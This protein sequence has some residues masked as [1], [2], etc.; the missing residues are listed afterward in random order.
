MCLVPRILILHKCSSG[1]PLGGKHVLVNH[2]LSLDDLKLHGQNQ[3]VTLSL[4][5]TVEVFSNDIC[6]QFGL[7]KCANLFIRRGKVQADLTP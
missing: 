1:Y 7:D 5:T 6:M 4:V 3:W 2:L